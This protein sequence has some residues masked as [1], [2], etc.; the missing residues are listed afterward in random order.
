MLVLLPRVGLEVLFGQSLV[1][2]GT[3]PA[4]PGV[5]KTKRCN[6]PLGPQMLPASF[7]TLINS[8]K[9]VQNLIDDRRE[10]MFISYLEIYNNDGP[11]P[12]QSQQIQSLHST[13]EGTGLVLLSHN[14][15]LSVKSFHSTAPLFEVAFAT[16]S[17]WGLPAEPMNWSGYDLLSREETT[18]KLEDAGMLK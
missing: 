2:G 13:A 7:R 4:A 3:L 8:P 1:P 5:Q 18:S 11:N 12:S 15:P 14:A 17:C 10:G 9:L 6:V 16:F